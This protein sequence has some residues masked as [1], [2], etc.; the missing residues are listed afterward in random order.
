MCRLCLFLAPAVALLLTGEVEAQTPQSGVPSRPSQ[1]TPLATP[2]FVPA[3]ATQTTTPGVPSRPTQLTPLALPGAPAQVTR[4]NQPGVPSQPRQLTPPGQGI[5]T[6]PPGFTTPLYRIPSVA[7]ELALSPQQVETLNRITTQLQGRYSP[8]LN[9]FYSLSPADRAARTQ[10]LI[11]EYNAQWDRLAADVLNTRQMTRY[12]QLALQSRGLEAF[13]DTSVQQ[14]LKL[15][16]FQRQQF[17]SL[18]ARATRQ[19]NQF[20]QARWNNPDVAAHLADIYQ[21]Q[22]WTAANGILQPTQRTVWGQLTGTQ[23][24]LGRGP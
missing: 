24:T 9:S 7:Q 18:L 14:R 19:A 8:R 10:E 11:R 20:Q 17:Q 6:V 16:P 3:Q 15:T 1:L 4:T 2:G 23:P 13:G 21:R 5:P 22:W 12:G